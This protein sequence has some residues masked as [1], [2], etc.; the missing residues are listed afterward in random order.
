[1]TY[2]YQ[3]EYKKLHQIHDL[4]FSN[5]LSADAYVSFDQGINISI[6]DFEEF[7]SG[8]AANGKNYMVGR[9]K[10][11]KLKAWSNIEGVGI[12]LA[13]N[14]KFVQEKAVSN[15]THSLV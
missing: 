15:Q 13:P 10:L 14:A 12:I 5:E 9:V 8:Y 4:K 6:G 7:Q 3:Y 11:E 1:M 2:D